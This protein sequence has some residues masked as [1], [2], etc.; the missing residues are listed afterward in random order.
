VYLG[1]E[2]CPSF[3]G[4]RGL[5]APGREGVP[6]Q[7][8][9]GLAAGLEEWDSSSKLVPTPLACFPQFLVLAV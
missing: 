1:G 2:P 9:L 4:W 7:L 8:V 5:G 6:P 3:Y